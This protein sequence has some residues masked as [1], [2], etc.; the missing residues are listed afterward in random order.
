MKT[1]LKREVQYNGYRISIDNVDDNSLTIKLW[2]R[3]KDFDEGDLAYEDAPSFSKTYTKDEFLKDHFSKSSINEDH[4]FILFASPLRL[5]DY[6]KDDIIVNVFKHTV[7]SKSTIG[8]LR[9]VNKLNPLMYIAIPFASSSISD[10]TIIAEA[11]KFTVNNVVITDTYDLDPNPT[12]NGILPNITLSK[13]TNII[14]AQL[15]N[16]N[17]QPINQPNVDI[18]FETTSGSLSNYRSV[19]NAQ[20]IATTELIDA[21]DGKVKVGF[22]YFSGKAEIAI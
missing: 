16:S 1:Y 8:H 7:S 15:T 9:K 11:E 2:K 5:E 3:T 19:T 14:S 17:N 6:E 13:D 20:G 18:Y 10:W 22:K 4:A 12:L 21:T